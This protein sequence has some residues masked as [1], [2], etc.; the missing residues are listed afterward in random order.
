MRSNFYVGE[1]RPLLKAA[2]DF[3]RSLLCGKAPRQALNHV[4]RNGGIF[5]FA[6]SE[7]TPQDIKIVRIVKN[8]EVRQFNEI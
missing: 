7:R 6:P 5:N 3:E 4:G 1:C 8:S 2:Q